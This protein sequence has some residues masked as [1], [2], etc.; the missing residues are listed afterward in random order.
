MGKLANVILAIDDEPR[1]RRFVGACLE[2][3]GYSIRLAENASR[4]LNAAAE[5]RPD[6][7]ILDLGLPDMCGAE[8]SLAYDRPWTSR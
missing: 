6:L 3:Y 8:S 5:M 4:G 2:S 1:I 7:I